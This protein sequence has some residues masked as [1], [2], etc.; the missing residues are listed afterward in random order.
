LLSIRQ[1]RVACFTMV[2]NETMFLRIWHRY[3]SSL[4]GPE[5]LFVIDHNSDACRPADVLGDTRLNVL[6][7]PFDTPSQLAEG[8]QWAFDRERFNLISHLLVG[9]LSYYDTVIFNDADEVFVTD[10]AVHPNLR[11]FVMGIDDDVVAGVGL[12]IIHDR[13]EEAGLDPARPILDQRRNYVYRFHHS[14]PH[15]VSKPCRI[16]GHGCTRAFRLDPNLYLLH[17]K[18]I[19]WDMTLQRQE[20]LHGFFRQ[21]RGGK[22]SR[23]RFSMSE[24]ER[25]M[26]DMIRLPR[27]GEG[28]EH[29][30]LLAQ[31]FGEGQPMV[32]KPARAAM[33]RRT[34][35]PLVQLVD[36]LPIP[37]VRE[38]Q[39]VRR[40]LPERFRDIK[41]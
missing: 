37:A 2:R 28:L 18:Y 10:P 7:I 26:S 34:P 33:P 13:R 38:A 4:F 30:D 17:L 40:V 41:V 36:R 35:P 1:K 32:V 6:R 11:E 15:V 27:G 22:G 3:Y 24:M 20:T 23:W 9:F 39:L 29:H 25:S 19:D 8:D 12:E 5:N 16:G 21:G 14:K 31:W